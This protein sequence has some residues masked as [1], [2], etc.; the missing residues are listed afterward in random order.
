MTHTAPTRLVLASLSPRRRRL[1]AWLGVEFTSTAVDTDENL[2]TPLAADPGALA[3]SLAVEKALAARSEGT[4][5]E[6]VLLCFDTI[7]V[8]GGRV[9]GKPA[10]ADEARTM[11]R[12][13]SGRAHQVV[14]GVAVLLPHESIPATFAVTT[15]VR[16][17][18]LDDVAIAEWMSR[19][20]YVGCAGAY[21]IEGQVAEVTAEECYQNV[22][23]LPLCHL[24]HALSELLPETTRLVRPDAECN[25]ALARICRLAPRVLGD[26]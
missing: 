19:G 3:T 26:E 15:E 12:S 18:S 25:A 13:L 10:N 21:N 24:Y 7:V 9:L 17:A 11:L 4:D 20:E 2:D 6:A 22:A 8:H 16:M 5:D 23:G 14:T 1:L